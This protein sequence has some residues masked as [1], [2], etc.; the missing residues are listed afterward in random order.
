[1]RNYPN[2]IMVCGSGKNVGKTTLS[3]L[4]IN[5]F[6]QKG[7]EVYAVKTSTHLHSLDEDEDIVQCG[8]GFDVVKEKRRNTKDSSLFLQS[9][10]KES[11]FVQAQKPLINGVFN[12]VL[13]LFPEDA[14]IIC[15]SGGMREYITPGLFLFVTGEE[16]SKNLQFKPL[17][18]YELR[19]GV[20]F[21]Q[22]EIITKIPLDLF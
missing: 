14:L 20:D 5:Y 15:E 13:K 19:F 6:H 10:A 8:E 16:A 4:L 12:D 17:A 1:M 22:E 11:W 21:N 9:G 3:C 2:M 18:D 7:K